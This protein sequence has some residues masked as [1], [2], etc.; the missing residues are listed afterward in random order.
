MATVAMPPS[1]SETNRA[2]IIGALTPNAPGLEGGADCADSRAVIDALSN[3]EATEINIGA[4]GTAMRFLTAYYAVQIGREVT[5]DG[6][7]RM[8]QRPIGVLVDA[9]RSLGAN[10]E[11]AGQEGFPPLL[12][13]GKQLAGGRV[14]VDATISSQYVSALMM[15]APTMEQGLV[16]ELDG[17]VA[18]APYIN[19]TARMMRHA[20]ADVEVNPT[21]IAI[22]P[23]PYAPVAFEIGGDWSAASYWYEI[24]AISSGF[25]TLC[26]LDTEGAQGDSA[27]AEIFRDLGVVTSDPEEYPEGC[28]RAIE[29][30]GSPDPSPRLVRDFSD[31]PDLV[32]AVVVTAVMIGIPFRLSGVD[33]LRIKETDRIEALKAEM[34]KLGV[35]LRDSE[36]GILE[37]DGRRMPIAELPEFD[38]YDDHRMAMALA[39]VSLYL[40]GIVVRNAEVVGKSYPE[41]WQHLT[42]AGFAIEEVEQ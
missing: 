4:A 5:L 28:A 19:L 24:E 39:P 40:P 2:L 6:S 34:L 8:R 14:C 15:I 21:Q 18:S 27:V 38:T 31:T 11:Y 3:P 13:K 41:F 29:L 9:L 1:K 37:W 10:I 20:G 32:Q 17:D 30:C 7:E 22:A 16:I 26:G 25:I 36:P 42:D 23:K 35:A 33:T 12:I